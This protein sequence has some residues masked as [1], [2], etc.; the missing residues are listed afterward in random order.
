MVKAVILAAGKGERL[1]P[2][3]NDRPKCCIKFKNKTLLEY[4]IRT[5]KSI[6]ISNITLVGG[7]K[8]EKLKP[9]NHEIL[10]NKNYA[11]TNMV[12]SLFFSDDFYKKLNDNLL[13]SYGDIIYQKKNLQE[14]VKSKHDITLMIDKNWKKLWQVRMENPLDD[15]ESLILSNKN[16]ILEIGKKVKNYDQIHGQ[17]T[18]LIYI[19]KKMILKLR[20]FYFSN[21]FNLEK[22]NMYLTDFFQILIK[23]KFDIYASLV[24]GGWLEFDTLNDIKVYNELVLNSKLEKY[25]KFD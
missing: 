12:S 16:K 11:T 17:Y 10:V 23:N 20:N 6:G 22:K 3:T 25:F 4:Q 1:K 8:F 21:N 24:L 9:Y 18:G 14:L 2:L 13:I 5:L 15:A 19:K 7:Y